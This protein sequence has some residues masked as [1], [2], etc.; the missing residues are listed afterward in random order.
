MS[1]SHPSSDARQSAIDSTS[2]PPLTD[3]FAVL[4][5]ARALG[6]LLAERDG[7]L[8]YRGSQEAV[9]AELLEALLRHKQAL[10][11]L[12]REELDEERDL[13]PL[14]DSTGS[15]ELSPQQERLWVVNQMAAGSAATNIPVVCRFRGVLEPAALERALQALVRD[16]AALR[17]CFSMERGAL[18]A[19]T[20]GQVQVLLETHDAA[21]VPDD[22]EA[23][24][25]EVVRRPF[26]LAQA[27]L[28]RACLI[29]LGLDDAVLVVVISHLI[30]DAA[31]LQLLCEDLAEHYAAELRSAP[32]PQRTG[33]LQYADYVAWLRRKLAAGAFDE[34]LSYWTQELGGRLP[35]LRIAGDHVATES[36][37]MEGAAEPVA[38]PADLTR[39][40]LQFSR[41]HGTTPYLVLL[42]VFLLQLYRYSSEQDLLVGTP[43]S[44]R[45]RESLARVVGPLANILVSRH[46]IAPGDTFSDL[47]DR[48][49]RTWRESLANEVPFELLLNRLRPER[50][51]MHSLFVQAM[52]DVRMDGTEQSGLRLGEATA[53]LIPFDTGA[54]NFDLHLSLSER[55]DALQGVLVY[56]TGLFEPESAKEFAADFTELVERTIERPQDSVAQLLSP[57]GCVRKSVVVAANFLAEAVVDSLETWLERLGVQAKTCLVAMD[58]LLPALLDQ[59]SPLSDM[60][61]VR[62]LLLDPAPLIA[63]AGL[64]RM[65]VEA[66]AV[67][68]GAGGELLCAILSPASEDMHCR[69]DQVAGLVEEIGAIAGL[70]V[71]DFGTVADLYGVELIGEQGHRLGAGPRYTEIY[72]LAVATHVARYTWRSL[73]APPKV[74]VVDCDYTLW[75]GA[76]SEMA[77]EELRVDAQRLRFQ[78][79]LL[80]QA[81]A[82]V[83]ICLCSRNDEVDVL[84]VLDGH[85]DML[86]RSDSVTAMR[87]NHL[88]KSQNLA[89]LAAQLNLSTDD[90][91]FIDDDPRE[92]AEAASN[93]PGLLWLQFPRE[94]MSISSWLDHLWV[95]DRG[96]NSKQG[97]IRTSFYAGNERR[98]AFA[99]RYATLRALLRESEFTWEVR[100]ASDQDD[101][102]IAELT[103]RTNQFN[104]NR[105]PMTSVQ[106][107]EW[108]GQPGARSWVLSARD[109]FGDYGTVGAVLTRAQGTHRRVEQF[110]LSCRAMHRGLE[111]VLLRGVAEWA[112][113]SGETALQLAFR[114]TPKNLPSRDFVDAVAGL[115][116]AEQA[117]AG[118]VVSTRVIGSGLD[119]LQAT[120][121]DK[122]FARQAEAEAGPDLV[123]APPSRGDRRTGAAHDVLRSLAADL[124]DMAVIA[125]AMRR[126]GRARD[127]RVEW[128]PPRS[129]SQRMLA[130]IVAEH[131]NV[132]DPGIQDNLFALGLD[133]LRALQI[134]SHLSGRG[135]PI[136]IEDVFEQVTIESL[137]RLC[138]T[139]GKRTDAYAGEA[140]AR[141]AFFGDLDSRQI[142]ALRAEGVEAA[143]P[144]SSTQ[145]GM[146]FHADLDRESSLYQ[147]V[148][149]F[150]LRGPFHEE[151]F[152]QVL[153][154]IV[155]KHPA[156]RTSFE[157]VGF[158]TPMQLVHSDVDI[159]LQIVDLREFGPA[160]Q[161]PRLDAWLAGEPLRH[162]D[163]A[164]PPLIRYA[165]HLLDDDVFQVTFTQHHAMLDGWSL[166]SLVKEL[167]GAYSAIL[168]GRELPA[169]VPPAPTFADFI[170]Q[171]ESAAQSE[172]QREFWRRKLAGL[173]SSEV[174]RRGSPAAQ[175][176][177]RAEVRHVSIPLSLSRSLFDTA[178]LAGAPIKSVLL[179]AHIRAVMYLTGE[180]DVVSGLLVNG[181]PEGGESDR[182]LGLFVNSLPFRV[183]ANGGSWLDLIGEVFARERELYPYR[184][185]PLRELQKMSDTSQLFE[186]MF[187][188]THFHVL[189]GTRDSRRFEVLDTF[190]FVRDNFLL[191]AFF[192][193]DPFDDENIRL[194]LG[195]DAGRI[196]ADELDRVAALYLE[197]LTGIATGPQRTCFP[198][199]LPAGV[200]GHLKRHQGRQASNI[201]LLPVHR[202]VALNA[203][204][205][206][207]HIALAGDGGQISYAELDRCARSIASAL[208][209][210]G[211][212]PE[213]VVAVAMETG[214]DAVMAILGILHA[215]AAY[216]PVDPAYPAQRVEWMLSDSGADA[217]IV[218]RDT[219]GIAEGID[220][221]RF[222]DLLAG[223]RV[224]EVEDESDAGPELAYVIYTSGST[225]RPKGVMVSHESLSHLFEASRSTLPS[226]PGETWLLF[227]SLSF[228]FSVWEM[229]APLVAGGT[230]VLVEQTQRL[231]PDALRQ[232]LI[233]R[234]VDVLN[235]T[236]SAASRLLAASGPLD[237]L[238]R[239]WPVQ[240]LILGGEALPRALA[241][242]LLD[243]GIAPWN[244]YGPTEATVWAGAVAIRDKADLDLLGRPFENMTLDVLGPT[245]QQAVVMVPGEICI[246]GKGLARGYHG[247]QA[248]TAE[249]FVPDPLGR[250]SGAR[251]Y[252][253]GDVGRYLADGDLQYLER[254]DQQ[255]KVRG[256][257][258]ELGEIE[259][260][261]EAL[262]EI[263]QAVA[264]V[265]SGEVQV[266]VGY[267]TVNPRMA[268]DRTELRAALERQLPAYMFPEH[269]LELATFPTTPNGKLDRSALGTRPLSV[270]QP[271]AT[272]LS[273][274]EF[275]AAEVWSSVLGVPVERA[276]AH[277]FD[278]GGDSVKA[279][280]VTAR[281]RL[282][283][284]DALP[285][286]ELFRNVTLKDYAA[287]L[288]RYREEVARIS[289]GFPLHSSGASE[290]PLT[291]AQRRLWIVDQLVE[292]KAV[293]NIPL[294]FECRG[295]LDVAVLEEALQNVLRRQRALAVR[296]KTVDDEPVQEYRPGSLP[297][298]NRHSLG[299]ALS[300]CAEEEHGRIIEERILTLVQTPFDLET[301]PLLR[302][303]LLEV[304]EGLAY[305]VGVI[306]HLVADA[307]SVALLR[308]EL[309]EQY[310]LCAQGVVDQAQALQV[311]YFDYAGWQHEIVSER[312]L[313]A[314]Y[315]FWRE[316]LS[317][318]PPAFSLGARPALDHRQKVHVSAIEFDVAASEAL[319]AL[320]RQCGVTLFSLLLAAFKTALYVQSGQRDLW[321]GTGVANRT[322]P[323]TEP[324]VGL[325]VNTLVFRTQLQ[326]SWSLTRTAAEVQKQVLVAHE[327]QEVPYEELV[328]LANPPRVGRD[329]PLFH[330]LFELHNV[331]NPRVTF[332]GLELDPV[333]I[334]NG[335]AKYGI[336]LQ[337]QENPSGLG[338]HLEIDASV[339]TMEDT[340]ALSEVFCQV[341]QTLLHDPQ[342]TLASLP[343]KRG[344]RS[345]ACCP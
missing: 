95:L 309:A 141:K 38:L 267:Y 331:P 345:R 213:S 131:L 318:G 90:F 168:A 235:L 123:P 182:S 134:A 146:V 27:P 175:E 64:R 281:L 74:I 324:I 124:P 266:L 10:L 242:R 199:E 201:R 179:A 174:S 314:S 284:S 58:E 108:R 263:A 229:W 125:R 250:G 218:D 338:G 248:L 96:P 157:I 140:T 223:G 204:R 329:R 67:R 65:M 28:L 183:R 205:W 36:P 63:D 272:A 339:Y 315:A 187:T 305:L 39:K 16:H 12:L 180:V 40:L 196:S 293:Y 62:V 116:G 243:A 163:I 340:E 99:Q 240:R 190:N 3:P 344:A 53:D 162:F 127:V 49:Q 306:H 325:F 195:Y 105:S 20:D 46:Q 169:P 184:L 197:L 77:M 89:S 291:H 170:D 336:S 245:L 277:F 32:L 316:R 21:D 209:L 34:R 228:D 296:I 2:R 147:V 30:A 317:G 217:L 86:L 107:A 7:A 19:R 271:P 54:A 45:D 72:G 50:L 106:L 149:S 211:I 94:T 210:Q 220:I 299:E 101:E 31:S 18:R 254:W 285:L 88:S 292:H 237:E 269:L 76:C 133:S 257:R 23:I 274:D 167:L 233:D 261:M 87:I 295:A 100:E 343:A 153:V 226:M 22:G 172:E 181:R 17:T 278:L 61:G 43:V 297:K 35:V 155:R 104:L 208:V 341:V 60:D 252:R 225:G 191:Q 93:H 51:S 68:A 15:S 47:L 164:T 66:L 132:Q 115:E 319:K 148:D 145:A 85:P 117:E 327:H 328:R 4:A 136:S 158:R 26:D 185:F 82:G 42:G 130:A 178:L 289:Q 279:A 304:K 173:R 48:V 56:R 275:I 121:L 307:W 73:S 290:A 280:Q 312:H 301:G 41:T 265:L 120:L 221:C 25:R 139:P 5:H 238:A 330:A 59:Q 171:E 57:R 239:T 337:L 255:R 13:V 109:R 150:K 321:I 258:I 70:T 310:R 342:A 83:P 244:F 326:P 273:T 97:R 283:V 198:T 144:L 188:F 298:L 313:S 333:E 103:R 113:T 129:E 224:N 69:G 189:D 212:G 214:P 14:S 236:P 231:D 119:R 55:D 71:E 246:G 37:S 264:V 294:V 232:G 128:V 177:I 192:D 159:P 251:L 137:A 122:P 118:C 222:Q 114:A 230:L 81:E 270:A 193:I 154:H 253:T 287:V 161:Q 323:L 91:V 216:L 24:V 249:R 29:R 84:K 152:R 219:A 332:P 215:G 286:R 303:E 111:Y 241:Q 276:D 79:L 98:T 194:M 206:P 75:D 92:C 300:G 288:P 110:L 186:Y 308:A 200:A 143:Y 126:S 320:A 334:G 176:E 234:Q 138:E 207:D 33:G 160:A 202:Q 165:V 311:D 282:R 9:G 302:I 256:Y 78:R 156:L 11:Q 227:H 1:H 322:H 166:N 102:R 259:A 151:L 262:P 335:F 80:Q 8:V 52:L 135:Y 203:R 44:G 142:E 268:I 112:A 260:Q 247:R 6:I